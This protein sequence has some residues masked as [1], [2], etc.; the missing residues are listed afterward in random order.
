MDSSMDRYL[1]QLL[2]NRY[3]ML[4]IIGSGGMAVVFKARCNVLNRYVAIKML[5]D[6]LAAD[7]DFLRRFQTESQAVA[8]LSHPNI[9]S[10]YDVSRGSPHEYIVME[11]IEGI[12]LKQYMR[13]KGEPLTP[14]E[15]THFAIQIAKALSHAHSR[16]IIHRD[17]KPHNIML[18][19]DGTIKVA[20]F[21]IARLA[22]TQNTMTQET[23]GS[24]HYI[25]PEQAKGEHVDE[26]SDLYSFGVVLYEM[27]SGR[28]PFE[29]DSAVSVAIQHISSIPVLPR[30]I[31]PEIPERLEEITMTAM[32][33]DLDGRYVSAEEI[34][35]DLEA[36]RK[37]MDSSSMQG[38]SENYVQPHRGEGR[39]LISENVKPIS[40]SGELSKES[41][42]RRRG[43]ATKVSMLSGVFCVVVFIFAVFIFLWQ[44]WLKDIF[45]DPQ[46]R[47]IPDFVGSQYEE[48][49]NS[50]ELKAL[51]DFVVTEVI[52]LDH[53]KG[54]IIKQNPE[55][56]KSIML[57]NGHIKVEL[58]VSSGETT[59]GVPD[60]A[61]KEY[62]EAQ[63]E[64][65]RLGFVVTIETVASDSITKDYVVSTIPAIGEKAEY[66][67]TV[68]IEV[69]GGPEKETVAVP[70]LVG[71]SQ[72]DATA[73]LEQVGLVA[74]I[75]P[76]ESEKTAGVIVYQNIEA[77]TLVN[78][79]SS[80]VIHVSLGSGGTVQGGNGSGNN[81]AR[82]GDGQQGRDSQEETPLEENG[83]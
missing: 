56:G 17:I 47:T 26:R 3:E 59:V 44:F 19:R 8:K 9:V 10:V 43:R 64:L 28:L 58:T 14:K 12:T 55:H 31:H 33:P 74:S 78:K 2:D 79:H 40:T 81:A 7:S 22:D 46:R 1:G 15:A 71:Q 6:D 60:V 68:V 53:P 41:Y 54:E 36:Y 4:E 50:G 63:Q 5:R 77:G 48:V 67:S 70:D 49:I 38:A 69:S 72:T 37:Q 27:L 51:F 75:V 25:S 32:N 29:G 42:E 30:D 45:S 34:L 80:V 24:V 62:K 52:S 23:L 13:K 35:V 21:G 76:V 11:L 61:N 73:M 20:D 66:G 39:Y 83:D 16:G 65:K 18:L 57:T 82:D